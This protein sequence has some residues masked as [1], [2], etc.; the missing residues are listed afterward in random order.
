MQQDLV[1]LLN[2]V[3]Q[4]AREEPVDEQERQEFIFHMTDWAESLPR[5]ADLYANPSSYSVDDAATIIGELLYH[6]SGH[7]AEAARKYDYFPDPFSGGED[8][9]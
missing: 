4:K 2:A 9:V 5:L 8:D 7:I 6:T 3:Y 1:K